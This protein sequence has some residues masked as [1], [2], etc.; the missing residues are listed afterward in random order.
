MLSQSGFVAFENDFKMWALF[1][2]KISSLKKI[3]F[4][5]CKKKTT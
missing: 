1:N 3:I 5:G 4:K 2:L